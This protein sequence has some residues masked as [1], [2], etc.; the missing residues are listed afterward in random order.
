[1]LSLLG[2]LTSANKAYQK[3]QPSDIQISQHCAAQLL[4]RFYDKV[5]S[6]SI[7]STA[8]NAFW[9]QRNVLDSK[10]APRWGNIKRGQEAHHQIQWPDSR[11]NQQV[12]LQERHQRG[13]SQERQL[14]VVQVSLNALQ[15]SLDQD[16]LDHL[17]WRPNQQCW[18]HCPK[19]KHSTNP[20]NQTRERDLKQQ[21]KESQRRRKR[22]PEHLRVL[23]TMPQIKS[24]HQEHTFP[25]Q[26]AQPGYLVIQLSFNPA[27]STFS[28]T[29][30]NWAKKI[31]ELVDSVERWKRATNS[32]LDQKYLTA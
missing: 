14:Q 8:Y 30:E 12:H 27:L 18:E 2:N 3:A 4:N 17:R 32:V 19:H 13:Q 21:Q 10:F 31:R 23:Q 25:S 24:N 9:N 15:L 28:A 5:P 7:S 1:M 22:D 29:K 26:D 11:D 20:A 6:K 16:H